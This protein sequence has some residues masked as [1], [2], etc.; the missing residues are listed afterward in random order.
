MD[1]LLLNLAITLVWVVVAES[2]GLPTLVVGYGV[3]AVLTWLSARA[4][5]RRFYLAGLWGALR[6]LGRLLFEQLKASLSVSW[7]VLNPRSRPE[8]GIIEVPLRVQKPWQKLMVANM[9]TL[10]PGSVST[11]FSPD[12]TRL[13]VHAVDVNPA[14]HMVESAR[15]FEQLVWGV[16]E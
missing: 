10:T 1:Q 14:G 15:L 4:L 3:G 12:R 9:I 6:L 11:M 5:G 16:W 8:P 7:L 13:Y 2:Y